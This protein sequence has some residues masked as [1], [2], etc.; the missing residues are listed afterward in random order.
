MS[1]ATVEKW[2]S[3]YEPCT[4]VSAVSQICKFA[5]LRDLTPES[6]FSVLMGTKNE[7]GELPEFVKETAQLLSNV[8]NETQILLHNALKKS[9]KQL[10]ANT[11]LIKEVLQTTPAKTKLLN[12]IVGLNEAQANSLLLLIESF[13]FSLERTL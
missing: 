1:K 13:L 10:E 12:K 8:D 5:G 3:P 2:E 6:F 9:H 11:P 4:V 7:I